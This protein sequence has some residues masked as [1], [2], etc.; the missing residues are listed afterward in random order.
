MDKQI[1]KTVVHGVLKTNRGLYAVI[2]AERDM[3]TCVDAKVRLDEEKIDVSS[4]A[5]ELMKGHN[6]FYAAEMVG[7]MIYI[8]FSEG[9]IWGHRSNF[10]VQFSR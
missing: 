7:E 3:T 6:L 10:T 5:L 4:Q 8:G 1:D 2:N 9:I